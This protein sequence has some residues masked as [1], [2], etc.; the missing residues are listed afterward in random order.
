MGTLTR[1]P[2]ATTGTLPSARSAPAGAK[3][4]TF[5]RPFSNHV[6]VRGS[7]SF[8]LEYA[9]NT[10]S[11][12]APDVMPP[13]TRT[14]P[15]SRR[16]TATKPSRG[17]LR[18][19]VAFHVPAPGS[20]TSAAML[21]SHAPP[22]VQTLSDPTTRTRPSSRRAACVL[23]RASFRAPAA[24]QAD[25]STAGAEE[26]GGT[27]DGAG[28]RA[29]VGAGG[30]V[31]HPA[32]ATVTTRAESLLHVARR[33]IVASSSEAGVGGSRDPVRTEV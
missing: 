22:G 27:G 28:V 23:A 8:V 5:R 14:P 21:S 18:L 33:S 13:V 32:I 4:A 29:A 30:V 15:S 1:E 6:P 19:S 26:A 16:A 31:P 7:Y 10:P 3:R 20:N 24:T 25:P 17:A 11:V 9:P 12:G 2:S